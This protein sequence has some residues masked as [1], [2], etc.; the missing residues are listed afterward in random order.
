VRA[1]RVIVLG[2]AL[3]SASWCA[4]SR[5]G[6]APAAAPPDTARTLARVAGGRAITLDAAV[7]RW[8]EDRPGTPA[9]SITPA[10]ARGFLD[11]LVDE[12]VL[13]EAAVR[14][15][16]P[17]DPADSS[18]HAAL[19]DRLALAAALGAAL[20]SARAAAPDSAHDD[21][22]VGVLAR[23]RLVA[24]LAPVWDD[25]A[26]ARLARA[27]AARPRPSPDSSLAAQ[28][29]ALEQPP[30]LAPADTAR[31][32]ARTRAGAVRVA[33]VVA[34]WSRLSVAY[35]PWIDTPEQV[36]DLVA[37]RLFE[38]ALRREAASA[39]WDAEPR[40]AAALARD[41]E[42]VARRRWLEREVLAG[43]APDSAAIAA[44]WAGHAAEWSRPRRA[45]GI[46]LVLDDREAAVRMGAALR[47]AAA[48]ESLAAR[49]ARRG[50]DYRFAVG[51]ADDSALFARAVA[52]GPGAVIGPFSDGG[53][54]WIAR[55]TAIDPPRQ[56]TLD[57][58]R[59]DVTRRW[60]GAE[61]ERRA[62]ARA[63]RLRAD[64]RV[65]E[66]PGAAARLA[67]ALRAATGGASAGHAGGSGRPAAP[68]AK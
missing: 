5:A 9:D 26:C 27:F 41:A 62:R 21:A 63:A 18:A 53:A 29:R 50:A 12:A 54:W 51:A 14:E 15:A 42:D 20:D 1:Q 6:A 19:R 52:G 13:T 48:A 55:V 30:R 22:A 67:T 46:R 34:G 25:S 35:R 40:V 3:L 17:W 47:D 32:L 31:A 59:E 8:R 23:E 7:A 43:I 16:A 57:Q 44:Y 64:V 24:R 38:D 36:R 11:L 45:R 2:M 28:L 61:A 68:R 4:G 56:P 33:D 58:V 49:A 66:P 60:Y 39:R 65:D 37:N 10:V